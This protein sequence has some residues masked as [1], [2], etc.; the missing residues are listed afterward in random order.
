MSPFVHEVPVRF[1]DIDFAGV[2]FFARIF[3]YAH[4]ANEAWLRS[5][6][7][8][9][10]VPVAERGFALPFVHAEADYH[11]PIRGG[12]T[13]KVEVEPIAVGKTSYTL[14]SRLFAASGTCCAT[15]TTV[16]VSADPVT[17]RPQPLPEQLRKAIA[18]RLSADA[19]ERRDS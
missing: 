8:H 5:L 7:C 2:V 16:Q 4:D 9:L 6:G 3:Y 11:E 13:I 18:A 1:H 19:D 17:R 12:Q 14:R 10:E 15:V